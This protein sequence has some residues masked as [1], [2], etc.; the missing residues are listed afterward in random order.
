[1]NSQTLTIAVEHG[2]QATVN[3][4]EDGRVHLHLGGPEDLMAP[5]IIFEKEGNR[6][7]LTLGGIGYADPQDG[8]QIKTVSSPEPGQTLQDV[9]GHVHFMVMNHKSL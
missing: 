1:M 4:R 9:L 2:P 7:N 6:I 3:I 5:G 8:K